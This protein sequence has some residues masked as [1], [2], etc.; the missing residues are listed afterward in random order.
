[1]LSKLNEWGPLT[2]LLF[3]IF[4]LIAIPGAI[5]VIVDPGT[6]SY[7]GYI[8]TLQKFAYA[9]AAAFAGKGIFQ[10]GKAIIENGKTGSAPAKTPPAEPPP[11]I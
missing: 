2:F 3:L 4:L 10:I 5:L 7:S 8:D 11:Q 1:M 6:L 9:V